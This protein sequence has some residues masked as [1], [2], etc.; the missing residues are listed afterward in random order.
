MLKNLFGNTFDLN[1]DGKMDNFEKRVE[2]TA[3]LDEIRVQEG[4]Q[5]PLSDM[6]KDQ[7]A[8]L[9]AKSGIDPSDFGY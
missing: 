4:I 8:Q 3:F 5:T 1:K 7:V 6:S 9:V 2:Y